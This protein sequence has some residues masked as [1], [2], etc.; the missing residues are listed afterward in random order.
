MFAS[1]NDCGADAVITKIDEDKRLVF[2][3][4][5]I[6]KDAEGRVLLDR[7]NDFIDDEVELEQAAYLYALNSRDGGEMHIRKGVSTMVESVV[8]TKEKQEALGIPAGT[9]PVGWWIGFR[10]N[11]DRVWDAVKKGD[12]A[13]FSVHGTGQRRP[14]ILKDGEF[15]EVEKAAC[16]VATANVEVNKRNRSAAIEN[17]DYGPASGDERCGNCRAYDQSP[18]MMKCITDGG[19]ASAEAVAK[20]EVGYCKSLDFMCASKN[21][22]DGWVAGGPITKREFV[23]EEDPRDEV[24]PMRVALSYFEVLAKAQKRKSNKVATVMREFKA[25]K[26]KSSSGKPVT[27]PRQALAIAISEQRA[28]VKKHA[29]KPG[30]TQE[31]HGNRRGTKKPKLGDPDSVAEDVWYGRSAKVGSGDGAKF[32]EIKE[33]V[34]DEKKLYSAKARALAKTLRESRI[35]DEPETTEAMDQVSMATGGR[36]DGLKYRVKDEESIARKI[37]SDAADT[38]KPLDEV[39]AEMNDILRYTMVYPDGRYSASVGKALEALEAQ[40]F[41][42]SNVKNFWEEGDI[43][44]GVNLKVVHPKGYEVELQFHTESSL[45]VKDASHNIYKKY[46]KE[47]NPLNRYQ[48]YKEMQAIWNTADVP[49]PK[50]WRNIARSTQR[51]YPYESLS[52]EYR[53]S[54][55]SRTQ[56]GYTGMAA[57]R[58]LGKSAQ[59]FYRHFDYKTGQT[60][61]YFRITV[62]DKKKQVIEEK[63]DAQ[64][65]SWVPD[66]GY[67]CSWYQFSGTGDLEPTT[68][69]LLGK[70]AEKNIPTNP[71]LYAQVK[72]EA[73]TKFDVYPSAYANGWIV[74]QYKARGGRYQTIKK[75]LSHDQSTHTPRRLAGRRRFGGIFDSDQEARQKMKDAAKK[76]LKDVGMSDKEVAEVLSRGG[77][78]GLASI[79]RAAL[80][81]DGFSEGQTKVLV[82]SYKPT[83]PEVIPGRSKTATQTRIATAGRKGGPKDFMEAQRLVRD[84]SDRIMSPIPTMIRGRKVEALASGKFLIR[85]SSGGKQVRVD[86]KTLERWANGDI[87]RLPGLGGI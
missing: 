66:P 65:N 32:V 56:S 86:A 44:D 22:C 41:K 85:Q 2:G 57:R 53:Q 46:R 33:N 81:R 36:L 58:M 25:G 1:M 26:L 27:N 61:G 7:Q 4:A 5:S 71:Q 82:G 8:F 63:W 75:H 49:R 69:P 55:G 13:G 45:S 48:Q 50:G 78:P 40:G 6:I 76:T 74:Q 34:V 30:H 38:G 77:R 52:P 17:A 28:A 10:V 11:D 79:A 24:L 35:K 23:I 72:A 60:F 15:T 43:F 20:R 42:V 29:A 80:K 84:A 3:W 83:P 70:A 64:Q 14:E 37:D 9:M 21:T 87:E 54:L 62:D 18:A 19:V 59:R 47:Q 51:S 12:Y 68:N 73:K 39:A 16:P 31:S 67:R